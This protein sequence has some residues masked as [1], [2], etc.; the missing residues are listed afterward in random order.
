MI[1]REGPARQSARGAHASYLSIISWNYW[2]G[3]GGPWCKVQNGGPKQVLHGFTSFL[4]L[5][6][7]VFNLINVSGCIGSGM[8]GAR[9]SN[10]C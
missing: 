8:Q 6:F 1:I 3:D 2:M 9:C 4:L 10:M 5:I 7:L